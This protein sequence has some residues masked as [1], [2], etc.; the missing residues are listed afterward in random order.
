MHNVIK[1]KRKVN[2]AVKV[3]RNIRKYLRKI[4]RFILY[5][6]TYYLMQ[7]GVSH[8]THPLRL[9]KVTFTERRVE[10]HDLQSFTIWVLSII[11]QIQRTSG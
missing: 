11:P 10:K 1:R 7:Q 8:S 3:I 2:S 5:L 4:H 6:L 9:T